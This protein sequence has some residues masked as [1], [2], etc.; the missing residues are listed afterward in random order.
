MRCQAGFTLRQPCYD[1]YSA[2][3]LV[4]DL[5]GER[6]TRR[7]ENIHPRTELHHAESLTRPDGRAFLHAAHDPAGEHADDLEA[8]GGPR[9][10]GEHELR[11]VLLRVKRNALVALRDAHEIDDL[12]GF[13]LAQL[14]DI[15][16]I[17]GA[18]QQPGRRRPAASLRGRAVRR[19]TIR[20]RCL[21]RAIRRG[22]VRRAG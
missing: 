8:G 10:E 15:R 12:E 21:R 1:C 17:V 22:S 5:H 4:V 14:A 20:C 9:H 6:R 13:L 11:S 19:G 16:R 2:N 18:V 7:H 3:D